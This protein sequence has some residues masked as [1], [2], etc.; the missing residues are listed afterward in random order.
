MSSRTVSDARSRAAWQR[1]PL[2]RVWALGRRQVRVGALLGLAGALSV[3]AAGA[4]RAASSLVDV[5]SFAELTRGDVI[6][7]LRSKYDVDLLK[8]EPRKPEPEPQPEPEPEPEPEQPPPAADELAAPPPAAAEAAEV[9]TREADPDEPLDLTGEGFVTGTSARYAGGVTASTGTS[10]KA[11]RRRDAK[12]EGVGNPPKA[13]KKATVAVSGP[14]LSRSAVP[15][16][17]GTWRDCPFPAE[18]NI[19]QINQAVVTVIV[20]VNEQGRAKSVTIL[21]DPGYGFGRQA[22]SCAL[23]KRYSPGLNR[24]GQAVTKTTPPI[25]IRFSR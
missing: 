11:V 2:F 12:P 24:S 17:K 23:R 21:S 1:D 15:L 16:N 19:E 6:E 22:Q 18:A 4:A 8:P 14:D 13:Q 3:H 7:R 5:A 20:T 25:S 10:K 9:L